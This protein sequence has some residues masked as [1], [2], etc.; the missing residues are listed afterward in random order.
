MKNIESDIL[1]EI[2]S[3]VEMVNGVI[4]IPDISYADKTHSSGRWL[5][6]FPEPSMERQEEY[7]EKMIERD[8]EDKY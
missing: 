2:T 5:P 7:I 3:S 6:A 4:K 8:K 1:A